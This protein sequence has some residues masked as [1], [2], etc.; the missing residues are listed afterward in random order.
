M[1]LHSKFA[2]WAFSMVSGYNHEK[3]WRRR[4][5]VVNP[6]SKTPFLLK[7]YYLFYVKK[8]DAKW[9]CT[10]GTNLNSGAKFASAP[11]FLHG[12]NGIIVGHDWSIGKNCTI[13][14]RVTFVAGGGVKCLIM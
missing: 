12:P 4:E 6:A 14:Q 9:K 1:N 2:K 7:L 10:F 5:K 11:I 8:V 13:A 3:Y